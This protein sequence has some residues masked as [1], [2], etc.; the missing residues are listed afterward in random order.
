[1]PVRLSNQFRLHFIVFLWGFTGVLGALI[2]LEA[3]QLVFYRMGFAIVALWIWAF[4]RKKD[5]RVTP[6]QL[7]KYLLAGGIIAIHWVTFFHAIKISNVS[8]T[9]ACMSSAAVFVSILEPIFYRRKLRL[10]EILLSL[11]GVA[12]L[13]LIFQF[14]GDYREG[15]LVAL[16]SAFLA[17]LFSTLNGKFVQNDKA[18]KISIYELSGGWLLLTLFLAATGELNSGLPSLVGLDI[19]WLLI[20][21]TIC[22]AYA[23][24]VSVDVMKEL[25]P[26][27][28]TLTINLEPVYGI[29][30]ALLV[31]KQEESM[32]AYFYFGTLIILASVV[33]NGIL[34]K[35]GERGKLKFSQDK[36]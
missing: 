25:S 34:K 15:I 13:F 26:F 22:T 7:G 19:L 18:E 33:L 17:A 12:G 35:R 29:I 14:E 31:F 32:T 5:V 11:L 23:F 27:T 28:V 3:L 1:M 9:L 10:Q 4:F 8:V 21:G 24:I 16:F 20:L 36:E 30:L 2:S 6:I